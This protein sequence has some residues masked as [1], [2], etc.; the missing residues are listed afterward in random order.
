M[1]SFCKNFSLLEE[2]VVVSFSQKKPRFYENSTLTALL[3]KSNNFNKYVFSV[4]FFFPEVFCIFL[5]F[6]WNENYSSSS[7]DFIKISSMHPYARS[8]LLINR[9]K[10]IIRVINFVTSILRMVNII[11]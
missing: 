6:L 5:R 2:L 10:I 1:R 8:T 11:L 4:I 7:N 3:S 9:K